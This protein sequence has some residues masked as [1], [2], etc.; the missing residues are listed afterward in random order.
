MFVD[1]LLEASLGF[2]RQRDE[3]RFRL[4]RRVESEL[5]VEQCFDDVT[6]LGFQLFIDFGFGPSSRAWWRIG[7]QQPRGETVLDVSLDETAFQRLGLNAAGQTDGSARNEERLG[8]ARLAVDDDG[9][10]AEHF[11]P[12]RHVSPL[13][14]AY[15]SKP[16]IHPA[17]SSRATSKPR[18]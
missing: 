8:F 16:P 11:E 10:A 6:E 5:Q 14:F 17:N 7:E 9:P 2:R 13:P 12:L 4:A 15:R 3:L 1:E 18:G